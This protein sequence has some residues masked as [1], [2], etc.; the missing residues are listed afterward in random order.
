[1]NEKLNLRLRE[2]KNRNMSDVKNKFV[3]VDN[4]I[5]AG[6]VIFHRQLHKSPKGGGWWYY[7]SDQNKLILYGSSFDFGSVTKEQV[8]SAELGGSFQNMDD[9][10][11]IF[12]ERDNLDVLKILM[13]HLGDDEGMKCATECDFI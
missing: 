11:I 5:I 6:R 9:I 10:E 1:M 12:D 8:M 4:E 3:L 2:S 13:D 7:H